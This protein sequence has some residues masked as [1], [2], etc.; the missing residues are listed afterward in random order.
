MSPV[1]YLLLI[2]LITALALVAQVIAVRKCRTA[3][4]Q[5]ARKYEMNFAATDRFRLT[6][7][8]HGQLPVFGASRITVSDLIFSSNNTTHR[9]VF[10]IE[11]TVGAVFGHQRLR[12]VGGY[13]ESVRR[14]GQSIKGVAM[15]SNSDVPTRVAYSQILDRMKSTSAE[16]P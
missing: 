13:E 15:F 12:C 6:E 9:Y 7:R 11:Y 2:V 5:L 8:V 14:G 4:L 16:L 3:L 1:Q 10:T